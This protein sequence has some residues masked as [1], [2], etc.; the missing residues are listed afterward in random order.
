MI[1]FFKYWYNK[2][3]SNV[4]HK[5]RLV[6]MNEAF[7]ERFGFRLSRFNVFIA[8]GMS[9]IAL[10]AGTTLL[11]A[12]T[13]L[14]EFI[15]GF[16]R[17]HIVQLTYQNQAKLDSLATLVQAQEQ[18]LFAM[19]LAISGEIPFEDIRENNGEDTEVRIS[20]ADIVFERS[21]DDDLLREQ[22]RGRERFNLAQ[23]PRPRTETVAYTND[24]AHF[25]TAFNTQSHSPMSFF[26]PLKGTI[27]REFD[28]QNEHFGI[29]IT[30][31]MNDV[32]KAVQNGTVIEAEWT[33]DDGYIISIQHENNLRSVYKHNSA[34]LRRVGDFVR[35]G[36]PIAFIGTQGEGFKGP[37]LHF[38]LWFHD[39]PV[40]PRDYVPF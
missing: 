12:F 13:P 2:F 19:N 3:F 28:A 35:A 39:T 33:I 32:I 15:P 8:V 11:I 37:I 36:Q 26:I 16:T 22:V 4:H 21:R 20:S 6:I 24:I 30:G 14:R 27:L 18:L 1:G 23:R 17:E 7:E 5:Y 38:E 40:N 9:T 31:G 10:I 29:D 34:L 25:A